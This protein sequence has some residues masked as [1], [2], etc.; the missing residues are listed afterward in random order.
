MRQN[1]RKPEVEICPFGVSRNLLAAS[2]EDMPV[3]PVTPFS[4]RDEWTDDD[5]ED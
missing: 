2:N 3:V 5:W 4:R 1:Y